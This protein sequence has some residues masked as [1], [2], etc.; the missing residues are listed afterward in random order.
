MLNAPFALTDASCWRR[1]D[2][3]IVQARNEG[4]GDLAVAALIEHEGRFLLVEAPPT[5]DFDT[6]GISWELPTGRIRPNEPLLQGLGRILAEHYSYG[7]ARINGFLGQ[8]DHCHE[9]GFTVRVFTFAVE[10]A[11]PDSICRTAHL[12]HRW[13]RGEDLVLAVRDISPILQAYYQ[14]YCA[15]ARFH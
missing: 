15:N 2:D 11:Q 13:A 3:L 7:L 14:E 1:L 12:G 6:A 10:P 4:I 9:G 5:S 8:S